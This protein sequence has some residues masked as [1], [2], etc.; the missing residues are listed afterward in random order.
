MFTSTRKKK[1]RN[2]PIPISISIPIHDV[3][4]SAMNT[5]R[6][7]L[8]LPIAPKNKPEKRHGGGGGSGGGSGHPRP[9]R[10][11]P[12]QS[13]RRIRQDLHPQDQVL[14]CRT[15]RGLLDQSGRTIR[16]PNCTWFTTTMEPYEISSTHD[17]VGEEA[18][19]EVV[20]D[21]NA[22]KGSSFF[23]QEDSHDSYQ[24][25]N[26]GGWPINGASITG[27]K[28]R[29]QWLSYMKRL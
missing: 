20:E 24:C 12:R 7:P 17:V 25:I 2:D 26:T 6:M 23:P 10:T 8:L 22:G 11:N 21:A 29:F 27:A 5:A 16:I 4:V 18:P 9:N 1:K 14:S 15:R 28:R 3:L 13:H 19:I